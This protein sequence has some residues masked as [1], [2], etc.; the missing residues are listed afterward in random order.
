MLTAYLTNPWFPPNTSASCS[1]SDAVARADSGCCSQCSCYHQARHGAFQKH[2]CKTDAFWVRLRLASDSWCE[3]YRSENG[4]GDRAM[5][6]VFKNVTLR[7][8]QNLPA[9]A[10]LC[11]HPTL[12]SHGMVSTKIKAKKGMNFWNNVYKQTP[13]LPYLEW[14]NIYIQAFFVW[15]GSKNL[16]PKSEIIGITTAVNNLLCKP[17]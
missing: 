10:L 15:A 5:R 9:H 3:Q 6:C 11:S 12:L 2:L 14:I 4:A 17:L 7:S 1:V 16:K 13:L 8:V